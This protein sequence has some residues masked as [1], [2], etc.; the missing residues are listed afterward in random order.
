MYKDGE[1]IG[2]LAPGVP[3]PESLEQ[4]PYVGKKAFK[5]I[6]PLKNKSA[7]IMAVN[8]IEEPLSSLQYL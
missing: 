7:I 2:T 8:L 5:V 1:I 4:D 6:A 3:L